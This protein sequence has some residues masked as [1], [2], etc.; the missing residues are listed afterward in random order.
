MYI[1]NIIRFMKNHA[2]LLGLIFLTFCGT[3]VATNPDSTPPSHEIFNELLKKYVNEEGL[4]NYKGFQKERIKF[5][6]YLRQLEVNAP[7]EKWTENEKLAYWINTYNAYTIELVLNHYPI[8]SIKDIGSKIKIPFVSTG[9]DIKFIPMGDEKY[10]LNTIEHGIIRKQFEEPRIHF[11]LVCAAISCP[12]LQNEAY[13]P[14]QLDAQLT[15]AAR[16]FLSDT[17]KNEI[18]NAG[19]PKLSKLFSWYKGDFTKETTLVEFLNQYTPKKLNAKA[20]IEYKDYD[21]ALNEQ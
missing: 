7:N 3:T 18:I 13:D 16:D 12:K 5:K 21:W 6:K 11:A 17:S 14:E 19:Y 15:A 9:W 20:D 1:N 8:E 10:A 2:P 4:V